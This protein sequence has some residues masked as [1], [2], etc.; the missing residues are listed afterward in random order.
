MLAQDSGIVISSNSSGCKII[1]NNIANFRTQIIV[2]GNN[3]LVSE[4]N[5]TDTF[6]SSC[7]RAISWL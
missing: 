1:G 2:G 3:N 7:N 4:N 6:E 5:L